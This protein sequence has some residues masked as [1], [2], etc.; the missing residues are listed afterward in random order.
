[1]RDIDRFIVDQPGHSVL[2]GP[3]LSFGQHRLPEDLNKCRRT[4]ALRALPLLFKLLGGNGITWKGVHR[5]IMN[6]V[7][8]S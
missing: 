1:M 8:D 4:A 2:L 3:E 6:K 7:R 5:P